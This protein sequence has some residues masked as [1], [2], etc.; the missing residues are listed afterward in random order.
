M[1]RTT[2]LT[3]AVLLASLMVAPAHASSRLQSQLNRLGFDVDVATLSKS[4]QAQIEATLRS[5]DTANEKR[6]FIRSTLK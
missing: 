4:Q 5:S 2:T 6:A 1:K 3:T